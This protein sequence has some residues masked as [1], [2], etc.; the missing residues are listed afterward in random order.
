MTEPA[1]HPQRDAMLDD[2]RELRVALTDFYHLADYF[3]WSEIIFN[4]ISVRVP[5]PEHHYLV[6]PFGLTYDEITPELLVKVDPDGHL[7]EPS[8]YPANPAGFAL[9][10]VIHANRPDIGCIAHVHTTAVSAVA[11][12]RAGLRHDS[13][14]GAQFAGRIGYH[15]F[16]GI[17]LYAEEKARMLAALGDRPILVLRNHGVAV[18]GP[19][20]ASTFSLLLRFQRACEIQMRQDAMAGEDIVLDQAVRDRCVQD[21]AAIMQGGRAATMLFDAAVRKMR[22][23]RAGAGY[24]VTLAPRP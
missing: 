7:V 8:D 1:R 14:P 18:C 20:V 22:R 3:G 12:K 13:F 10:G 19:D 15:D 16:E 9:H 23:D 6:N 5:G 17:T 24:N 11:G 21:A 2:E 4:H